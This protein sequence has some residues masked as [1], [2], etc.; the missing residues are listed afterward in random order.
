[1]AS[2]QFVQMPSAQLQPFLVQVGPFLFVQFLAGQTLRSDISLLL[3]KMFLY[4]YVQI[5]Y[6]Q[7]LSYIIDRPLVEGDVLAN[8]RLL[9]PLLEI[10]GR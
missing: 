10:E 8:L 7:W 5:C 4:F 3:Q 6:K 9:N 2:G 1:M